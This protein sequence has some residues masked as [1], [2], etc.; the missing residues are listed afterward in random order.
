MAQDVGQQRRYVCALLM[1][2]DSVA[3]AR[4]YASEMSLDDDSPMLH[5]IVDVLDALARKQIGEENA[6]GR[7]T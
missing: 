2:S 5:A 3:I 4:G 1:A 6:G 7:P